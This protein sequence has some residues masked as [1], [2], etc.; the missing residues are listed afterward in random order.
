METDSTA[1]FRD[2][3]LDELSR[4]VVLDLSDRIALWLQLDE[5]NPPR[6]IPDFGLVGQSSRMIRLRLDIERAASLDIPVLLRGETGT[7][8]ELVAHAVNR[9]SRRGSRQLVTVNMAALPPSL[10]AA[11][12]FGAASG[13]FTG[14]ERKRRGYFE[15]ASGSTLFL[16][17]IG[18]TPIE[19]QA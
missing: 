3:S 12:L 9:A 14:A 11:E 8:K 1:G 2:L 7:G 5:P 10:A 18:E 13:A 16:D 4:G 6:S 17:E 19:A 15:R